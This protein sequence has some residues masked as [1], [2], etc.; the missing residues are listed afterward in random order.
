MRMELK[1]H[2]HDL[3]AWHAHA[4]AAGTLPPGW[5]RAFASAGPHED[6]RH[7]AGEEHRELGDAEP[8]QRQLA[9]D[10]LSSLLAVEPAERPSAA[11]ALIGPFLNAEC[12]LDG[13]SAPAPRP[14]TLEALVA[15]TLSAPPARLVAEQCVLPDAPAEETH[16][17]RMR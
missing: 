9:W 16:A 3:R 1:G 10:L 6:A 15:S 4:A 13:E 14:W 2:H 8:L 11:E 5:S 7:H 12:E 17:H